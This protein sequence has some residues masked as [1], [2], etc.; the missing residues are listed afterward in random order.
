[1]ATAEFENWWAEVQRQ[2]GGLRGTAA[3]E[4]ARH[5][6]RRLRAANA[7]D[8][9]EFLDQLLLVLLQRHRAFGVALFMLENLTDPAA[10]DLIVRHLR[11]LPPPQSDDEEA[12][13]A[14]LVRVLAAADDDALMPVVEDYLLRREIVPVWSTVPWALWPHRK[15]LFGQAWTRFFRECDPAEWVNTLVIRSF[16]CE[17][18]AIDAVRHPLEREHDERWPVLRGALLRQAGLASW[19]TAEQRADLE[20][21]L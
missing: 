21:N 20:K 13:L 7:A 14:D 4:T 16:L 18:E 2:P 1:M 9:T 15:E 8:Q 12:H 11:P 17:P 5:L 3:L 6:S 19:L 10:L